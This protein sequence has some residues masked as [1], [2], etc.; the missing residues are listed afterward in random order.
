MLKTLDVLIGLTVIM[1]VL[2]FVTVGWVIV[3]GLFTFSPAM[4]FDYPDHAFQFDRNLLAATGADD[5]LFEVAQRLEEVALS[6][7]YFISRKLY[8]NVDFYSGIT[9]KAMGFPVSMF[10]VLFALA[11]TVGWIAQWSEMIEDPSQRIGRPRQVYTGAPQRDY[12]TVD[13]GPDAP[14]TLTGLDLQA[15]DGDVEDEPDDGGH[16]DGGQRAGMRMAALAAANGGT[17]FLDEIGNLSLQTQAKLLSAIQNKTIVRV[18]SNKPIPVDIRLICATNEN[19]DKMVKDGLFRE[20]RLA[21][22]GDPWRFPNALGLGIDIQHV[23][24]FRWRVYPQ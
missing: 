10:T 6:D 19:L 15:V 4:A 1:L 18:G 24:P 23:P 12:V 22:G 7:E 21:V 2:V 13:I 5:A 3:A 8:P 16:D 9:L 14:G 17:L 20:E 11:R